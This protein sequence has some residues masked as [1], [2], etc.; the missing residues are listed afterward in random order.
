MR[1]P[2]HTTIHH[3]FGRGCK[4]KP[5]M[6]Q[7]LVSKPSLL[8][9]SQLPGPP[10]EYMK[11]KYG[12]A[13][14]LLDLISK[15]PTLYFANHC[16]FPLASLYADVISPSLLCTLDVMALAPAGHLFLSH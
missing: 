3:C 15:P 5:L 14:G 10:P 12:A 9:S 6:L 11:V 1:T 16:Q 13:A 4:N 8:P 7:S 2:R